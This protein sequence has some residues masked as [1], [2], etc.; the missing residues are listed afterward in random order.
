MVAPSRSAPVSGQLPEQSK[1]LPLSVTSLV[2]H[3]GRAM[4]IGIMALT[5][6]LVSVGFALMLRNNSTLS[7]WTD[8]AYSL[9]TA[10]Q[11]LGNVWSESLGLQRQGPVYFL[12]LA[13]W[14]KLAPGLWGARLLSTVFV[15]GAVLFAGLTA[16]DV[17]PRDRWLYPLLVALCPYTLW[18]GSEARVYAMSL[19]LASL[20]TYLLLRALAQP[21]P[22][23][24]WIG[25][26]LTTAFGVIAFY[27][28]AL[29]PVGQVLAAYAVGSREARRS[30]CIAAGGTILMLLP[31]VP[32]AWS[33]VSQS[34]LPEWNNLIQ[35]FDAPQ[36]HVSMIGSIVNAAGFM[37]GSVM[38]SPIIIDRA[39]VRLFAILL[40]LVAGGIAVAR[41][42]TAMNPAC[43]F[44]L[45]CFGIIASGLIL[46]IVLRPGLIR[47]RYAV[48]LVVP[49]MA[50]IASCVTAI[51]AERLR[52]VL[53]VAWCGLM[54]VSMISYQRNNQSVQDW[55]GISTYIAARGQPHEPILVHSADGVLPLKFEM[56]GSN[57]VRGIPAE[58]DL[59]VYDPGEL[60]VSSVAQVDS[61]LTPLLSGQGTIWLVLNR[62]LTPR[63]G[64]AYVDQF[65][66]AS[67]RT[68]DSVSAPGLSAY[69]VQ[70]RSQN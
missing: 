52:T 31:W 19:F 5:G 38:R 12:S 65:R 3:S 59:V 57:P 51:P 34:W 4:Q 50:A 68:I 70:L 33:Q 18:A 63:F 39:P 69:H 10:T 43:R 62:S 28:M 49:T 30:L 1:S 25:Y 35:P 53:V 16:R 27:P 45:L 37:A 17:M 26:A 9:H 2:V 22:L 64:T 40:V 47:D 11:S 15:G 6:L 54:G 60:R 14:L 61:A 13:T 58:P 55:R 56:H 8:E 41:G 32:I 7:I 66:V 20:S 67:L 48:I 44:F 21:R 46:L 24:Y 42:K 23:V 29:L 36:Q